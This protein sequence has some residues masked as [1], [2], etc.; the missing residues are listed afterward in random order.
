M[1]DLI[2]INPPHPQL[3]H[4]DAQAPVGLLY[5]AAAAEA[6]GMSVRIMDMASKRTPAL[7]RWPTAHCYGITGTYLDARIINALAE[8]IKAAHPGARV[9][10]GGPISLSPDRVDMQH[11]DCLVRGEAEDDIA[12]LVEGTTADIH[13]CAP[14]DVDAIP[15]PARHLWRGRLGGNVFAGDPP[16]DGPSTTIASSRG[17]P[18]RCAFCASQSLVSR[19]VRC[20]DPQNVV[21]EMEE[22]LTRFGVRMFRFSD[23]F[24]TARPRHIGDLCAA[25]RRS[26]ILG[27]GRA[28]AWRCSIAVQPNDPALFSM[29]RHAGCR[30]VSLGVESM[31][32]A[33]LNL[34][35]CK[36]GTVDDAREALRNA[37]NA[38]LVTR[39]LLMIGTPGTTRTTAARNIL[40]LHEKREGM[41][42]L[43]DAV[44]I[45]VFTPLPGCAVAA[46]PE[47]FGCRIRPGAL[48]GTGLCLY[49]PGGRN[50]IEPN[51]DVDGLSYE[52]LR[53]QMQ[54][55]VDVAEMLGRIGRG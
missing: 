11:V 55:T 25:I 41:L 32:Q 49:G 43:A 53:S 44:A 47:R 45:A 20:R 40:F 29:M 52:A 27:N 36:K 39:A 18:W 19:K 15:W 24:L 38:G 35:N 26:Q 46:D 51:I 30:E 4:P 2:L 1:T 13:T 28:I 9:I 16:F 12:A 5:L 54:L 48:D 31:D 50:P 21:A 10:V 42:P 37:G 33:V 23:E 22:C 6:E 3:V 8:Q 17:C 14:V 7:N 34:L